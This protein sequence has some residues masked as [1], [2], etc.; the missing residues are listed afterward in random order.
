MKLLV[1]QAFFHEF[2]FDKETFKT[3]DEFRIAENVQSS[4]VIKRER[5]LHHIPIN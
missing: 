4:N 3:L 5:G 2:A 1:E